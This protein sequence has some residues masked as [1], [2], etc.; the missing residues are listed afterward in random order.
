[1]QPPANIPKTFTP[2]AEM[3]LQG[4]DGAIDY[5]AVDKIKNR[6]R[7]AEFAAWGVRGKIWWDERTKNW[8]AEIW[9]KTIHITTI[10]CDII[11]DLAYTIRKQH[12]WK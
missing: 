4:N 11:E 7:F 5:E 3:I 9:K 8:Y 1:M 6:A 2:V 12:G 10:G